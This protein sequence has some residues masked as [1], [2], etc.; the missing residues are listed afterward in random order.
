MLESDLK[1]SERFSPDCWE[2]LSLEV[3]AIKSF[4]CHDLY[5]TTRLSGFSAEPKADL[6]RIM[7]S[8]ISAMV[9]SSYS[10]LYT[11]Q[12]KELTRA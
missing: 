7:H 5:C 2:V 10:I 9:I 1:T 4:S 12:I 3:S 11:L 8:H 6:N